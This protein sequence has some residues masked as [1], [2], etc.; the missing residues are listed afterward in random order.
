M[1]E[2]N[3]SYYAIIPANVRY[4]KT[5]PANAKLL[6]AEITGE[7]RKAH[8]FRCGMDSTIQ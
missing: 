6:Y 3:K 5:L 2:V 4:D 7:V 8:T 1:D